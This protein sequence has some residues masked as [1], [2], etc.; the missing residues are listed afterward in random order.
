MKRSSIRFLYCGIVFILL[1]SGCGLFS[2]KSAIPR[3][4]VNPLSDDPEYQRLSPFQQDLEYYLYVIRNSHPNPYAELPKAEFDSLAAQLKDDLATVTDT[5]RFAVLLSQ[6]T[7]RLG[8]GHT[9]VGMRT[10]GKLG[11]PIYPRWFPEGWY[12]YNID[13]LYFERFLGAKIVSINDRP[14]TEAMDRLMSLVPGEN[15]HWRRFQVRNRL[16]QPTSL[17]LLDL[18]APDGNLHLTLEQDDQTFDIVLEP[19]PSDRI[20]PM[21]FDGPT[22]PKNKLF[23]GEALPK[24]DVYYIQFN[25]FMD[26]RS[27]SDNKSLQLPE[28]MVLPDWGE[29]LTKTFH[30]VDS[31]GLNNIVVDLRYNTGGNSMLGNQF[32]FFCETPDSMLSYSTQ[33]C[34][35]E[36]LKGNYQWSDMLDYIAEQ[37]DIDK[38]DIVLPYRAKP[39]D[40]TRGSKVSREEFF[41]EIHNDESIWHLDKPKKLFSGNVIL[42]TGPISFSSAVDFATSCQD[43]GMVTIY[44]APTGGK[45]SCYGD[46]LSFTLPNSKIYC[47]CSWKYFRR[48]DPSRDPQDSLMPDVPV[49]WTKDDFFNKRDVTWERVLEDIRFGSVP[50]PREQTK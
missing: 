18:A 30:T 33:R 43:N 31:L 37:H 20:Q 47:T 8:D 50:Q 49:N 22:F 14:A 25:K 4:P 7:S 11:Y 23:W 40:P 36:L 35:S 48:P 5:S 3:Q 32:M 28:G 44:G 34:Y 26:K 6:F 27:A 15:I 10:R 12:V 16:S 17:K 2:D 41:A 42:L 24:D 39:L 45:P 13:S 29:F 1:L 38:D 21:E 19:G 46:I 9:S